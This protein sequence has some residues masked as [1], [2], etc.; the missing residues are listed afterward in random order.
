M[1]W[2]EAGLPGTGFAV[3]FE[4]SGELWTATPVAVGIAATE[5]RQS[6]DQ[7]VDPM[8]P[9]PQII[10]RVESKDRY[11]THVPVYDLTAAAG[12][13]GPNGVP[14]S[15][16]WVKVPNQKLGEGMFIAQVTGS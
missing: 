4:N 5:V 1:V 12:G 6:D 2:L 13:W 7:S 14:T 9:T 11:T 15:T 3:K 10:D 8:P 16:G